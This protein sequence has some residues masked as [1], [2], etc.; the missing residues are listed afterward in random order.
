MIVMLAGLQQ[1]IAVFSFHLPQQFSDTKQPNTLR[2]LHWNV[3]GWD[4]SKDK[5]ND[6]SYKPLMFELL[7]KENA[8]VLC[9]EEYA[10]RKNLDD[11]KSNVSTIT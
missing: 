9:F 6:D 7:Q 1:I 8:D 2:I 10:D 4:E 11:P 5:P 3:E